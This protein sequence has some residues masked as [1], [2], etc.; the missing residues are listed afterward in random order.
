M[1]KENHEIELKFRNFDPQVI[2][3]KL[4]NKGARFVGRVFEKTIRFDTPNSNL[5]KIGRFLR[6]RTGFKNTITF[7]QKIDNRKF[8]EREE[9]ELEISNPEK[10]KIILER[11][12]FTKVLIMEKHR[13]KWQLRETEVVID[14]LPMGTFLEIEGTEKSIKEMA[15]NLGLVLKDKILG[16]YWDLWKEFSK[17]KNIKDRNIIFDLIKKIKKTNANF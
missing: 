4:K 13:E 11:L 5:E 14:I 8:R 12:G 2:R 6:I 10:M 3:K 16:T 9:I 7:K 1:K 17:K 15:K